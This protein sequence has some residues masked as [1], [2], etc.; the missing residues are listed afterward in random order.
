MGAINE[1]TYG[2]HNFISYLL[3]SETERQSWKKHL[4]SEVQTSYAF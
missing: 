3:T 2:S 1:A 4:R